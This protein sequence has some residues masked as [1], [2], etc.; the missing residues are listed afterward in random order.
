MRIVFMGTPD[1]A[2]V[3][4]QRLHERG[5]E[6]AAVYTKPDT[7]KNRGM[8]LAQSPVKEYAL[9]VGLPVVQP[10]SFRDDAA[11]EELRALA[12]DLIVVV[13]YG[14]I[15]PQRVL[16]IPKLGCINMHAS[17]LPELRGSAPV[18]RSIL[19]HCDEAGVT[20]M[21]LSAGMDEGDIIEIRKTVIQP[22]ETSE[23]L[24][25]RL[26]TI[27]APLCADTVRAIENGTAKR[28][29]QDPS[30]ATYAP[31]LR[32]EESPIDW[33]QP[34]RYIID[35]VRGLVPWPVATATLG[36]TE[37][38]IYRVEY[39][40]QKTEKAPGALVALTKKGLLVACRGG[41]VVLVRELQAQGGKRM[42]APDYFRG[43][44]ITI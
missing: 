7:P 18:Q 14:K 30:R 31:M 39:T 44:P 22:L 24:M 4:L 6:I 43:H 36:G 28:I 35:Q 11:V 2:R 9:S 42:P 38:K 1:I 26:A 20:A 23:E 41:D 25:A 12:P 15:L 19:N 21:Y 40:D 37:F 27:A 10:Q 33:D 5:F 13:A 17:I 29:R 8:K 34:A 32:K 3:C 16:D